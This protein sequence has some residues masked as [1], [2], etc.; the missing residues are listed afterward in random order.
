MEGHAIVYANVYH[1]Y[2]VYR[3]ISSRPSPAQKSRQPE[4][5]I[6]GRRKDSR[7]VG[8]AS[9]TFKLA[10]KCRIRSMRTLER[11]A[12]RATREHPSSSFDDS[13]RKFD[14]PERARVLLSPKVRSGRKIK[15]SSPDRSS[16]MMTLLEGPSR[17]RWIRPSDSGSA[18]KLSRLERQRNISTKKQREQGVRRSVVTF[19]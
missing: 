13:T 8:N 1:V 9:E 17:A 5:S 3:L 6:L 7:I 16:S 11:D 19:A 14:S 15:S 2:H 12:Q 4:D 10:S 18:G